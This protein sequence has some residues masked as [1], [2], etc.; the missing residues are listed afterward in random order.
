MVHKVVYRDPHSASEVT[1]TL[2]WPDSSNM[3]PPE[4]IMVDVGGGVQK[5]HVFSKTLP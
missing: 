5:K 1:V 2:Q 4:D 3:T